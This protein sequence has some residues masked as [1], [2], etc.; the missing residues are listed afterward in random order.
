MRGNKTK[1]SRMIL[2]DWVFKANK[3]PRQRFT[4][5]GFCEGMFLT[6]ISVD[7]VSGHEQYDNVTCEEGKTQTEA[8]LKRSRN[9]GSSEIG[10][11]DTRVKNVFHMLQGHSKRQ[12]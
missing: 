4:W 9:E 3:T 12:A 11:G 6:L 2:T 5:K 8:T 7:F 10:E 1:T